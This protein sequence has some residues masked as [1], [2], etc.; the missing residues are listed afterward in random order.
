MSA[1]NLLPFGAPGSVGSVR[2]EVSGA[3]TN[4][5]GF[6]HG[7]IASSAQQPDVDLRA[8]IGKLMTAGPCASDGSTNKSG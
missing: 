3:C 7:V 5:A 8:D 1:M 6:R 2:S 4:F